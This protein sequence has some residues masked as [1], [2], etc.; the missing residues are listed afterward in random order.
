MN[1]PPDP[2]AI[3]NRSTALEHT[4]QGEGIGRDSSL[5]LH[6]SEVIQSSPV[7]AVFTQAGDE[8]GPSSDISLRNFVEQLPGTYQINFRQVEPQEIVSNVQEV[9]R[10]ALDEGGVILAGNCGVAAA[11]PYRLCDF[12][13]GNNK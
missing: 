1:R 11:V 2:K 5:I 6:G 3:T 4:G 9:N 13:L 12:V 10:A 7:V 8:K